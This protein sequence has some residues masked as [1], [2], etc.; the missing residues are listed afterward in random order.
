MLYQM[1]EIGNDYNIPMQGYLTIP[2]NNFDGGK[3]MIV[4]RILI[5]LNIIGLI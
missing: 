3:P 2:D 5:T 1:R 4:F